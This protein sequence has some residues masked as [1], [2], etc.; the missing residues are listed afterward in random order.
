[1]WLGDLGA[2]ILIGCG[3]GSTEI[4]LGVV[5][6]EELGEVL[7]V[8]ESSIFSEFPAPGDPGRFLARRAAIVIAFLFCPKSILNLDN[9][10]FSI[11][12]K[13]YESAFNLLRLRGE[14]GSRGFLEISVPDI[15]LFPV[16]TPLGF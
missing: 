14:S 5:H 11:L 12:F 7:A 2:E 13:T 16:E 3:L 8:T 15:W 9:N 4:C 6:P 1:M 10:Y